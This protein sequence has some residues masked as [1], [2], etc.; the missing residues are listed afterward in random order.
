MLSSLVRLSVERTLYRVS[1]FAFVVVTLFACGDKKTAS[2]SSEKLR[3]TLVEFF[4]VVPDKTT[5]AT[6][7]WRADAQSVRE[8]IERLYLANYVAKQNAPDAEKIR[9]QLQSLEIYFRVSSDTISMLSIVAGSHGKSDGKL[10]RKPGAKPGVETYDAL[11]HGEK[12]D[13]HA[14]VVYA[15]DEKGEHLAYVEGGAPIMAERVTQ[16]AEALIETYSRQL[17]TTGQPSR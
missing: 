14:I 15:V 12:G 13:Q 9:K 11:M 2:A 16:S 8:T 5:P 3:A 1:L 6:G 10:T 4:T 17:K 7:I